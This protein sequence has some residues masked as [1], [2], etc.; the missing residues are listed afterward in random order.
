[1]YISVIFLLLDNWCLHVSWSLF[2]WRRPHQEPGG[3]C[4]FMPKKAKLRSLLLKGQPVPSQTSPDGSMDL[5][6]GNKNT[7]NHRV[8]NEIWGVFPANSPLNQ[9]IDRFFP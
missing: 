8:S 2:L 7:G 3:S 5:F 1:M 9:S 4:Q 6:E